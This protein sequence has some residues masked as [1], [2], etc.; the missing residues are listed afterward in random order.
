MLERPRETVVAQ[1]LCHVNIKGAV[2]PEKLEKESLNNHSKCSQGSFDVTLPSIGSRINAW[3]HRR[4]ENEQASEHTMSNLFNLGSTRTEGNITL[5]YPDTPERKTKLV[6]KS[7][8]LRRN[9]IETE[10]EQKLLIEEEK[11]RHELSKLKTERP[12]NK[13]QTES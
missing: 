3:N 1:S 10:C 2:E 9:K 6:R 12:T 8:K 11:K 5:D 13:L 4:P 7:E